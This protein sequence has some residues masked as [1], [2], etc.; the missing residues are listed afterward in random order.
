MSETDHSPRDE[1]PPEKDAEARRALSRR[2]F[3][4]DE[5]G[6]AGLKAAK[7]L[8]ALGHLL[9]FALKETEKQRDERL[10]TNLWQLLMGREPKPEESAAGLELMRTAQTPDE[11]GD[12]LVDIAWALCQTKDFEELARPNRVLVRG[13]YRLAL[14]RLPTEEELAAALRILD[15][16]QEEGARIAA[17]EGLFTGLVRSA[18][19]VLRRR[20]A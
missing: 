18:D 19:S 1:A 20:L 3:I 16:V 7:Q 11:K 6:R 2:G 15:E 4:T 12:A 10:V 14:D 17:L 9:G 8:P 5:L 13:F